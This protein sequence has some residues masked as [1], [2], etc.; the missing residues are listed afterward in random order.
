[1]SL[2]TYQKYKI[3][4]DP[5]SKKTQGL[6]VGDIVR[7]QYVDG[8]NTYYSLMS[9][10]SVGVDNKVINGETKQSPFFIGA[11][12]DGDVPLN[13][14][15]LDFVRT[16]NLFNLER[17]GAM[18]LTASDSNSPN[19]S[20]LDKLGYEKSLSFPSYVSNYENHISK[21]SYGVIGINYLSRQYT[22]SSNDNSRI[23]K[24]QRNSTVATGFPEIGFKVSFKDEVELSSKVLVSYKVRT[25]KARSINY[26]FGYTD[27]S[28]V[29]RNTG[30]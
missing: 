24:V 9:V 7:R 11:L 30:F 14:E 19:L 23:F 29:F 15:I 5:E 17:S 1:M 4:I 10:L 12:L 2:I 22:Q 6:Q 26:T 16:T 3:S 27:G 18:Y 28:G 13:G 20:V 8:V 21:D 25:N